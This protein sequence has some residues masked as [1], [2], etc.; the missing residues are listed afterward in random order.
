MPQARAGGAE[1]TP[2]TA[3]SRVVS[4]PR[5][6]PLQQQFICLV[7]A[8]LAYAAAVIYRT[9]FTVDSVRYFCLL[10]DS[11]I[12][13]RYAANL[14]HHH[15]LVWN[16][17]G[18]RVE[19]YTNF[20]WV[21][22][23]A[24]FQL[25]PIPQSKI[26]LCIQ[27]SGAI[28]LAFNLVFVRKIAHALSHGSDTVALSAVAL[29]AFYFPLN[30]WALRGSEVAILT[31][32]VSAATWIAL[33]C[34]RSGKMSAG[35]YLLLGLSTLVRPD[36]AVFAGVILL[37]I[38]A[39][40]PGPRRL[41][42]FLIGLAIVALFAAAQAAFRLY[43]YGDLLPNTYYLKLTGFPLALRLS[44]GLFVTMVFALE[45]GFLPLLIVY[46]GTLRH[47]RAATGLLVP[48]IAAQVLYSIWVGGDAW[49][50]WRGSNRY[51]SIAMPLFLILVAYSLRLWTRQR[52]GRDASATKSSL[53]RAMI[54]ASAIA[55]LAANAANLTQLFLLNKPP[56]VDDNRVMVRE[57]ML[58][59]RLTKPQATIAVVWAGIIPY[60]S[61]R[62]S[63]DILGMNDRVIGH[64]EMHVDS[65]WRRFFTFRPGHLKWDYSYSVGRL[66]PD[67]VLHIWHIDPL[68]QPDLVRDYDI[69][70]LP[71]FT[72]FVRHGSTNVL[73]DRFEREW[74]NSRND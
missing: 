68:K 48:V 21:L 73:S 46:T 50:W 36:M 52:R 37:A 35:L 27:I 12:S 33:G 32:I 9:S 20:L 71:G 70:R 17:G 54:G 23:M 67:I 65:G 29:T 64:E 51:I 66:K 24:A 15:G 59:R 45:I 3:R 11:M 39:L 40:E 16:P 30:N 55:I 25:L 8:Y 43:Y 49:E 14:V 41:S 10:D 13:M 26:S 5:K 19:G 57:A 7:V 1:E 63:I 58:V 2:L 44:R 47:L 62:H 69:V 74:R 53:R 34:I 6:Y 72:W 22:Y 38:A 4:P 18:D 56:E 31:L 60:F 61:G 28:L 42:H